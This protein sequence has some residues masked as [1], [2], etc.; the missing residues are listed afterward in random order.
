MQQGLHSLESSDFVAAVQVA[1]TID[2]MVRDLEVIGHSIEEGL[3]DLP[4]PFSSKHECAPSSA[5][6]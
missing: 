6:E 3:A 2:A 5:H 4:L 1:A